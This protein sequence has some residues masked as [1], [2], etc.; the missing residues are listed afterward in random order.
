[1]EELGQ[2]MPALKIA[3]IDERDAY[4]AQKI[5]DSEG[6]K[7]VAIVGAGHMA[8]MCEAIR[9][10]SDTNLDE[11]NVIPNI[12]PVW[13]WVGWAIPA[14]IVCSLG[15]IGWTQGAEAASDN[16]VFW[17][18]ANAVPC[19]IGGVIAFAHPLTILAGFIAAP[20]TSLTPV[21]GAGY[22]TAFVQTWV[23]PPMVHEFQSVG[24]EIA[25]LKGWWSNRLLRILLTF[26][27]TT[28]G[29]AIGTWVGG[30]VIVTNLM[31]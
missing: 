2:V 27:L 20:F 26:I 25:T 28:L 9:S 24:D 29:S 5:R 21:I 8:G 19:A 1:M 10:G 11:I 18:L 16:A 13:K 31:K 12:S 14:L 4:L 30:S 3:L 17:L 15:Y 22:I 7:L 6:K 23:R